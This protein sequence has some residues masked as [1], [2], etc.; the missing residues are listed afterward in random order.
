MNKPESVDRSGASGLLCGV[1]AAKPD[2]RL[3]LLTLQSRDRPHV[4]EV[5]EELGIDENRAAYICQKWTERGWYNYGANVL[6]G[7]LEGDGLTATSVPGS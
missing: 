3:L 1:F 7:W 4:R 6:A 5:V 2:E